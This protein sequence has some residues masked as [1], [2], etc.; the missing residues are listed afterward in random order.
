MFQARAARSLMAPNVHR[1]LPTAAPT[2]SFVAMLVPH[3]NN[4]QRRSMH[5]FL[6]HV[7]FGCSSVRW[8]PIL[9]HVG[10]PVPSRSTSWR[11]IAASNILAS[12]VRLGAQHGNGEDERERERDRDHGV[13]APPTFCLS[14]CPR[15]SAPPCPC[16]RRVL[17]PSHSFPKL[18]IQQPP[19][20]RSCKPRQLAP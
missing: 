18:K 16:I 5:M 4:L 11:V 13:W 9:E 17:G 8:W 6:V 3:Q 12:A 20:S 14:V 10:P 7:L 19:L 1:P 2:N 15:S